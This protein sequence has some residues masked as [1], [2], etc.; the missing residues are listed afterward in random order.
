MKNWWK[1]TFGIGLICFLVALKLPDGYGYYSI[2]L[3]LFGIFLMALN[4]FMHTRNK[5]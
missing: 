4:G 5:D 2:F 3:I 1:Y